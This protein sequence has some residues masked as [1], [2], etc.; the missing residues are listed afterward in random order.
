M[1]AKDTNMS[2][3]AVDWN[4]PMFSSAQFDDAMP[5]E[6]PFGAGS[7]FDHFT[8]GNDFMNSPSG[9][10]IRTPSKP[11]VDYGAAAGV[12]DPQH[13]M[14]MMA[15]TSLESSSQDSASDSS[16][17][18]KR[19]NTSESPVSDPP[20]EGDGSGSGSGNVNVPKPG[21]L[22]GMADARRA[23]AANYQTHAK[24][25]HTPTQPMQDHKHTFDFNS[26]AS[27]PI[28]PGAFDA[29]LSLDEHVQGLAMPHVA[30]RFNQSPP[31][32]HFRSSSTRPTTG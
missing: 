12:P 9:L 3:N 20:V 28:N 16:S 25:S 21:S 7:A 6:S 4:D 19:K 8:T 13:A 10:P 14:H 11:G 17:R 31:V 29:A 23:A 27:S 15:S 22:H 5:A 32:R 2:D 24:S 26:A 1:D 30:T 18:E